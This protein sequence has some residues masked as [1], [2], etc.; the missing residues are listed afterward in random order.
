MNRIKRVLFSL[1]LF[2]VDEMDVHVINIAHVKEELL[3]D[4]C[5]EPT[6]MKEYG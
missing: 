1:S 2:V 6:T 4:K 5:A 3:V